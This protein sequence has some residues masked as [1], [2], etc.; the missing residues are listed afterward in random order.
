MTGY[1]YAL[2]SLTSLLWAGNQII[3]RAVAGHVPPIALGMLRWTLAALIILPFAWVHLRRDWPVVRR[4]AG[5]LL[6]LG[7]TAGGSVNTLQYIGLNHTTALNAL[8]INSSAPV[9]IA[10]TSFALFGE[11]LRAMQWLGILIS[12]LGVL[13]I[14]AEGRPSEILALSANPG[15]VLC[16]VAMVVWGLYTAL[17]RHRPAIHWLS[18]TAV[19]FAI[20]GVVTWPFFIAEHLS[21][22]TLAATMPTLLAVSYVAV[23]PS[24]IAYLC[25][26][27][28]V[29]IVGAAR[30]GVFMHLVPAFGAVLAF[31]LL[32]EAPHLYHAAGF[33]LTLGG[34]WLATRSR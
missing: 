7:V 11:R 10:L 21:G 6:L 27:R 30:A 2:L 4:N 29:E 14:L 20:S 1:A 23:F 5:V 33:A 26:N 8:L 34:I 24:L 9:L 19:T 32:G 18:F 12:L 16:L 31:V 28:G 17:L 3:G 13:S 22:R 15:D 25:Y